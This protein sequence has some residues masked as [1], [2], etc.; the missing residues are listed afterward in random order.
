[1]I[2][3]LDIELTQAVA[4]NSCIIHKINELVDVVNRILAVQE[5]YETIYNEDIVSML[6]PQNEEPADPY[7]EQKKWIGKVCKFWDDDK[8]NSSCGIL[9]SIDTETFK[10]PQFVCNDEY[11]YEYCEPVSPED[12]IIYKKD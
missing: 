7:A 6:T 12:D 2:E 3:K 11:D 9:T 5:Q 8:N 1:M 10:E 4:T